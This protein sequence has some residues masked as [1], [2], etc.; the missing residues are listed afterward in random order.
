MSSLVTLYMEALRGPWH[1]LTGLTVTVNSKECQ[2]VVVVKW[3]PLLLHSWLPKLIA[4]PLSTV[5][6][7]PRLTDPTRHDATKDSLMGDCKRQH[8]VVSLDGCL[9]WTEVMVVMAANNWRVCR[10]QRASSH[11]TP[12]T[13]QAPTIPQP[14]IR[15]A[16]PLSSVV[17][18]QSCLPSAALQSVSARMQQPPVSAAAPVIWNTNTTS[19]VVAGGIVLQV[20]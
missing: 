14:V 20:I 6:S 16:S 5:C 19:P 4:S 2:A 10:L 15:V 11:S 1:V 12:S 3:G 18:S 13:S 17:V 7:C 8:E 9:F